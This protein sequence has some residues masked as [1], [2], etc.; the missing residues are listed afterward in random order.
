[1][2]GR[3]NGTDLAFFIELGD[4]VEYQVSLELRERQGAHNAHLREPVLLLISLYGCAG[5]RA[6][7]AR[8]LALGVDGRVSGKHGLQ[9]ADAWVI[10]TWLGE[11]NKIHI[12]ALRGCG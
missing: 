7:V 12:N 1:M 5:K 9:V 6:K 10:G 8:D 11:T 4:G 2:S 3:D